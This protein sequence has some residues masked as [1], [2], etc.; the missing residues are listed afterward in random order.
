MAF[1]FNF[2]AD[3]IEDASLKAQ[4]GTL[5]GSTVIESPLSADPPKRDCV[6]VS[7]DDLVSVLPPWDW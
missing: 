5:H 4:V 7:L 1:Q 3:D 6:E 2:T